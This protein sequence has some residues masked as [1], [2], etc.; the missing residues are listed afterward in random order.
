MH[1]LILEVLA[2]S[3]TAASLP[4]GFWLVIKDFQISPGGGWRMIF[5][6]GDVLEYKTDKTLL[7][8]RAGQDDFRTIA[9]PIQGETKTDL[10]LWRYESNQMVAAFMDGTRPL[11]PSDAQK[12]VQDGIQ[13][14]GK[15]MT[16]TEAMKYL[17]TLQ[18]NQ[19]VTI[20][21]S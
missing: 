11:R 8:W 2:F 7:R 13:S 18:S 20:K 4:V 12:R 1:D 6:K 17:Q 5:H 9:P 15:T 3:K 16:A 14:G 19:K 10:E 21:L